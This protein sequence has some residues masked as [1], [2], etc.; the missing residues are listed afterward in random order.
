MPLHNVV[1]SIIMVFFFSYLKEAST[2]KHVNR[3]RNML[4]NRHNNNDLKFEKRT[5]RIPPEPVSVMR[6]KVTLKEAIF[7]KTIDNMIAVLAQFRGQRLN[8]QEQLTT[9]T[10]RDKFHSGLVVA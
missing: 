9:L 3:L 10:F 2:A 6:S 4:F 7:N 8:P 1:F 5:D